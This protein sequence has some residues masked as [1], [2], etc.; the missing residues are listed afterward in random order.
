MLKRLRSF[1]LNFIAVLLIV[2]VA[3]LPLLTRPGL[4]RHT[5]LE[6][7][8]FR[9]AEY[10]RLWAD[11]VV[12]PRWAANFY[13]GYGYPIFNYYAPFTYA[14]SSAYA[15]IPV[16]DIV[17]AVKGVMLTAFLLAAYG[18]YFLAR[19]HFGP[20]AG[21]I[22]AAAF[23]LS[24]YFV[25][26]EPFM[27]GDLAEFFALSLL[28]W[29]F[30]VFDRPRF[31][32]AQPLVLAILIFSHNLMALMAVGLLAACLLWRGLLIDKPRRWIG[33]AVSIGLALALTA[34]FWLPF[35]VERS[36][37]RLDV[38]GPGHFDYHNHFIPLSMLLSPSPALDFG[39]TTPKYIYNLGSAQWL[40]L[41]LA[42]ITAV[43]KRR[44]KAG[45]QAL[46]FVVM[47]LLL[48][49]L[50]TPASTFIWDAFPQTALIQFPWR[51]LGP[52]ALMLAMSG[53]WSVV[54]SQSVDSGIT[55][56]LS[57]VILLGLLVAALPTLYP[58]EWHADFGDTSAKGSI[59]FELSGVAL[60][61]TS[62]GDFLP[63]PVGTLPPANSALLTSYATT[64]DKL[65]R[66]SLP[67]GA[68]AQAEA[69]TAIYDRFKVSAP[70]EFRA[71]VLTFVFPGWRAYIDGHEVSIAPEDQS[72]L[73]TFPVPAGSHVIEVALQLTTPQLIGTLMSIG[74]A[75]II[76]VL[77]LRRRRASTDTDDVRVHHPTISLSLIFSVLLFLIVKIGVIDRCDSCF[78]Y[79]SPAGQVLGA[80]VK[81]VA[82]LGGHI[83]LLGY[84]VPV[85]E[86]KAGDS[87]P[88]TLYWKATA[89]VPKNY[90]VFAHVGVPGVPPFGQSD[91]LNPGDFPTTRWPLDKYVWDDHTVIIAPDTPPGEYELSVGLYTLGDG[92]RAPVFDEAGQIV[93]DHVVL[94]TRIKVISN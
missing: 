9:A 92:V 72:G 94:Q 2:V 60:G 23:V 51:F 29:V 17:T 22:A 27:R 42:A 4:P 12:Y 90:Q 39:A 14:L 41:I 3:A 53:Q 59:D 75:G 49:F 48:I 6:L 87:L 15:L 34:I 83:D 28:P 19:R 68:T 61:T 86:V 36:A 93:G 54:R 38:A 11:G 50:V 32:I 45:K 76:L 82:H 25:F 16:V 24:P 65:D 44:E 43:I 1:D 66:T 81:Q 64:I 57:L 5:D 21:V 26:I 69:H 37:V 79:T 35:F 71:R 55:R 31:S 74:A 47:A 84:D 13:Y 52:A 91:K 8:V 77:A 78:R 46:F 40:L 80:Q 18:A 58:P 67:A 73:M 20:M 62:T 7:H 30:L 70:N 85:V 63:T 33:D 88:L 56:Y 10:S 89:P